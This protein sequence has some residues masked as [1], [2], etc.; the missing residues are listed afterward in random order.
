MDDGG[1][2]DRIDRAILQV[3]SED[4]RAS[5]EKVAE[6]VGLSPTP[7][8]RRIK[9][10]EQSGVIAGYR[11]VIDPEK[12]GLD[13]AIYVLVTLTTGS[14]QMMTEFESA[15]KQMPEVQRCDLL[16]GPNCYLLSMRV[17]SMKCY[18][19]YLREYLVNL[20][21]VYAIDSRFVIGQ[22]K[23]TALVP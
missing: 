8:R 1:A 10:L 18:D 9:R 16:A 23:E 14:A 12:C 2:V 21:S 6:R 17:K 19:K 4:G 7:V 20:P 15:V 11:V 5:V 3:L 13:L 22:V